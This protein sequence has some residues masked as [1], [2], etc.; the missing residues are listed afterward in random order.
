M[1]GLDRDDVT[2]PQGRC[3]SHGSDIPYF[4]FLDS[5]R[6]GL[7]LSEH[8]SVAQ[9]LDK[10]VANIRQIDASLERF[11]P[12]YLHLLS[13]PSPHALPQELKGEALRRTMEEALVAMITSVTGTRP[14]VFIIEDWHWSDP[15]S[16]SALRRLLRVLGSY[17]LMVIVSYR[18]GFS[19][20]FAPAASRTAIRL[21]P[22][23]DAETEELMR[24]VTDAA[25]MHA[26]LAALICRNA[27]GNTLFVEE[28]C[29]SLLPKSARRTCTPTRRPA[30]TSTTRS[31]LRNRCPIRPRRSA[32]AYA[33]VRLAAPAP[34]PHRDARARNLERAC[35]FAEELND[36][37]RLTQVR[38]PANYVAAEL[39][40]AIDYARAW[41]ADEA[42]DAVAQRTSTNLARELKNPY[43]EAAS[44]HYRGIIRDQQGL[45]DAA[46]ADYA[47]AQA[48]AASA[49]DQFRVYIAK[50]MQG[51][52]RCI[53]GD[54]AG[55]RKLLEEGIAL[56]GQLG[57]TFLLGQ[58]KGFWR[59]R[60]GRPPVRGTAAAVRRGDRAGEESRGQVH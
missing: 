46:I 2:V 4:P 51:R 13:I 58:A 15:A 1:S 16:Q 32:G 35:A 39:E 23:N 44:L 37:R 43:A 5:L 50:F 24:S 34:A 36:R 6:R 52:A 33:I 48:V 40:R 47:S 49:G 57:T 19:Y 18:P 20:D 53:S 42:G 22:L 30:P 27:D 9:S 7:H 54:L 14:M 56:A 3:Q 26:G 28:T 38:T 8:D 59:L 45:W 12:F 25:Q 41:I 60:P 31:P 21:K 17:R 55:G 10:E 11:L 29:Y